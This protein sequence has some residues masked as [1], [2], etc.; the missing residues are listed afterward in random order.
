MLQTILPAR[1]NAGSTSPA[2]AESSA[3]N[4][5]GDVITAGSH[6][7]TR[8][9]A[10]AAGMARPPASASLRRSACPR[11]ARTRR[12]R[13]REPRVVLQQ[14]DERLPD[15]AGGAEHG[16]RNPVA[17]WRVGDHEL[18]NC[19]TRDAYVSTLARSSSTSTYS[20]GVCATWIEPGPNS[21][22][23][24]Q[25]PRSG[26]SDVYATG[27]TSK[28]S[29]M[30][31]CCAGMWSRTR[32]Q[33]RRPAPTRRSCVLDGPTSPTRRNITSASALAR[34]DVGLRA[35]RDRPDVDRG[36]AEHGI[37]REV[38]SWIVGSSASIGSMADAPSCGYA[39]CASRPRV[40]TMTRSDPLRRWR[41]CSRSARR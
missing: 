14:S 2:T 17:R 29:M 26:M 31:K 22:G 33:R 18:S 15:G 13:R 25:R 4:T 1:A 28:P 20:S 36:G 38:T 11:S 7:S 23:V 3:E 9:D 12:P 16:D 34:D 24:P 40:R 6:G 30:W 37:G 35:A 27:A 39:E 21:S 10:T 41:A 19:F 5:S 8:I 32:L